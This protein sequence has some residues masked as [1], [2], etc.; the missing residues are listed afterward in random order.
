M[1]FLKINGEDMEKEVDKLFVQQLLFHVLQKNQ[2]TLKILE[3]I[4]ECQD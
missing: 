2:F 1:D 4:E 3:K